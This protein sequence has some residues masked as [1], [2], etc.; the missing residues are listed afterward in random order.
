VGKNSGPIINTSRLRTGVH[1][2]LAERNP[3]QLPLPF[4]DCLYHVYFR[5]HSLLSRRRIEN[6]TFTE[7][8]KMKALLLPVHVILYR[9]PFVFTK[10]VPWLFLVMF[11]SEDIFH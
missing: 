8:G 11:H 1:K 10:G 6:A 2:I 7:G 5:R 9:G 4:S 3:R